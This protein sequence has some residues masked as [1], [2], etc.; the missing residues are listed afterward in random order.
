MI[1]KACKN[2]ADFSVGALVMWIQP[3]DK[4]YGVIIKTERGVWGDIA[5]VYWSITNA[6]TRH[7]IEH[8]HLISL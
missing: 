4:D 6:C 1:L 5:T 3:G 8:E 7:D 2:R